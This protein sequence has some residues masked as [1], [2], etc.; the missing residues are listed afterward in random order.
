MKKF[1]FTS[2]ILIIINSVLFS[3]NILN[4]D[5]EQGQQ[6]GW[7]QW[8]QGGYAVIGTADFFYST[9]I[10]PPVTPRSGQYMARIG[11]YAYEINSIS[12]TVKLPNTPKVY[13]ILYY[14]DRA[15]TTSE[16]A[17]VWVGAR[18]RVYAAGQVI[19]DRYQ[20]YYN[21]VNDW[22][23][24][25]FDLSAVTGQ[26]IEIGF[27]ADAASTSWSYLYIDD[28]SISSS[29]T[30]VGQE[31][32]PIDYVLE[33]N[34]PNPFN[35]ETEVKFSVPE[36]SSVNIVVYDVLGKKIADITE[37]KY[38]AGNYS[39]KWNADSFS[40]GIYF[41]TMTAKSENS[42]RSFRSVKKLALI[43]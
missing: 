27:R 28:V 41:L 16:C 7:T 29:L 13:L 15:S 37:G 36:W 38:S 33:Q 19:F 17:G 30:D 8:S 20:C 1:L 18:I 39:L 22:T 25:Y 23:M 35:P 21:T 11:G 9:D 42:E 40:S 3:Q 24:V 34:Y 5:F 4:G 26:T 31:C 32:R 2:V 10:T 6:S 12:Q 43:K 14:Q